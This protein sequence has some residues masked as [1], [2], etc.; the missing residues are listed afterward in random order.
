MGFSSK[1]FL[2]PS[3]FKLRFA[4]A[5]GGVVAA[6]AAAAAA[7]A[8]AVIAAAAIEKCAIGKLVPYVAVAGAVA[9]SWPAM[10]REHAAE[11]VAHLWEAL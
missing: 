1:G 4:S 7:V 6:A 2:G 11:P 9:G 8:A 3:G 10:A 5:R